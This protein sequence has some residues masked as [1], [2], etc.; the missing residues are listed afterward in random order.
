MDLNSEKQKI[1]EQI[2]R[3]KMDKVKYEQQL[4]GIER[5]IVYLQGQLALIDRL[6]EQTKLEIKPIDEAKT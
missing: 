1:L 5:G 6:I 4:D 2:Q 3:N